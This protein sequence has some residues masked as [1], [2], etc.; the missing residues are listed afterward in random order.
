[1]ELSNLKNIFKNI[2]WILFGCVILVSLAGLFTMNSFLPAQ[3]GVG[4]GL[5]FERQTIWL[6]IAISLF[7]IASFVDWSF[8]KNTKIVVSLFAVVG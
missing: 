6:C 5:F 2:D 7:F 8:L 4:D 3:A 1:M